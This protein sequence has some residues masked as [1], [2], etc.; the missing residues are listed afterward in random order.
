MTPY[1]MPDAM[2]MFILTLGQSLCM[3][4]WD[5]WFKVWVIWLWCPN[6]VKNNPFFGEFY[7]SFKHLDPKFDPICY[8]RCP[9]NDSFIFRTL[10]CVCNVEKFDSMYQWYDC[11]VQDIWKIAHFGCFS[12][13]IFGPLEANSPFWVI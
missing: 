1:L 5:I 9:I 2:W 6:Y 10:H 8:F 12:K 4:Q 11:Y 13:L 7:Y 3:Y